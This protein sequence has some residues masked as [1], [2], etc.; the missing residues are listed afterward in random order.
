MS[1]SPLVIE[2]LS[3]HYRTRPEKAL[4]N[5]SFELRPGELLLIAGSSGC[6]KTT[7][8]RCI[9]GLI[10][11][12]YKGERDGKVLLHGKDVS[13]MQIADVA[14]TVGTLLQDPERQI[15]ASNVFNEVAFG[16][17]NLGF[18]REEILSRVGMAMKR[19]KIEHLLER[20]T[21]NL[22]G[23]EKQKVAL[24]GLL[25]MNPSILML[26]EPLASLDPAS[27]HEALEVFRSLADEGKTVVLIEHRVEDA[28][29]AK[30]DRLLYMEGG[31]VKYLGSIDSLPTSI[32]HHEVKL[33]AEWVVK[34]V[35][36]AGKMPPRVESA[37]QE[38]RG[39]PLVVFENVDF[40]YNDE[41]PLILQ[42][43]NLQIN[44]GDLIAVLGPNGAGKSTLVKHAIGLLK[45][46]SGRVLVEG[47]DTK[48]MSVAQI[49]HSLGFVFQSPTHMLF[50]PTVREELEFG[51]KNLEMDSLAIPRL[52]AESVATMNLKGF[53]EYPPLGLSFGQQKRTT[54]AAVLAMQS[55]IMIMDEPTAGQDYSNY[56]HFMDAMCKPAHG[57]K[58]LVAENFAATLFI[59][60]DLD[61]AVTYANRVLLFGDKHIVADGKP[62]EVLK[63]FDLLTRYRVRPTSLLRMNLSLFSKTKQFLTAEALAAYS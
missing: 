29:F 46:T 52:V 25:A 50:A 55:K 30:P 18:P 32:D 63:D 36:Q 14:Q 35:R 1:Q 41:S 23:G 4:K 2:N 56:T 10:P 37:A 12:S 13:E 39:E 34:R 60:H 59:T 9:N 62:E 58:S 57:R 49:A 44:R 31:Q 21:F 43:V 24:A 45:P 26:D 47:N 27:A 17:E 48:S 33:P 16:P 20:E 22:S 54:I 15:V 61:L 19:L 51:P 42:D 8:A 11:R 38:K 28:I 40:R 6:G 53:E 5:V 7:L 3:F